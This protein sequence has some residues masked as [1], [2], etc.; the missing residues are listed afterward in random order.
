MRIQYLMLFLLSIAAVASAQTCKSNQYDMLNWMA[1]EIATV[2]GHYNV[3]FPQT[4]TFYWVK[5]ANG[6]PWDVDTFD[7]NYIYQSITE[8]DWNDPHTY[9]IFET[10]M[11]WMPRC[12]NIPATPGKIAS[13]TVDAT[14]TW[15]D[16]HSSCTSF[17]SQN[18]G[19][20]VNEIWGPY[21]QSIAGQAAAATLTLSYR[22]SCD[23]S[24]DSCR[25]KET[26]AMQPGN[27][28]VQW[29]Y[30]ELENG[31]YVQLNQTTHATTVSGS[32]SPVHPCW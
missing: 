22:Y 17:T 7:S 10:A 8:Q 2:N 15:F 20:V 6:Y 18:L 26:F 24:Y 29:T 9:K 14:K 28:M 13:I 23:S 5:S 12:I 32:I 31:E 1:P 19:Y 11:P 21:Q 30:Y 16:I 27:G 3:M 25:Y 4:G